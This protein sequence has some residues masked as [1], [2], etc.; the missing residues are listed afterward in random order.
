V[1]RLIKGKLGTK[2]FM[3][4]HGGFD[5]HANQAE[6]HQELMG[7]LSHAL[8]AFYEDLNKTGHDKCVLGMTFSEFGRRPFENGSNG[9]DHGAASTTLFF[10][11]GLNGNGF[12]GKHPNLADLD[13]NR[14]LNQSPSLNRNRSPSLNRN[15]S[16][17]RSQNQNQSLSLSLNWILFQK[18]LRTDLFTMMKMELQLHM[19]YTELCILIFSCTI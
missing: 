12:A 1:A 9:T 11:P 17:N 8:S 18:S 15:R 3:V 13:I 19:R 7:T 4:T 5:T 14:N 6:V 16:Q 2:V 10:G